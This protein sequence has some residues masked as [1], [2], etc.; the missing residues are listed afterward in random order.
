M[1][2][3]PARSPYRSLLRERQKEQTGDLILAA[4][5]TIL[6]SSDISAVTIA[7]VAR[8]AEVTER[9]VYRHFATRE[10]LLRAFWKETLQRLSGDLLD[11]PESVEGMQELTRRLFTMF[12]AEEGVMRAISASP[13]GR[14]FRRGPNEA[15]LAKIKGFLDPLLQGLPERERQDIAAAV[16]ALCSV[17]VWQHMRDYVG[18]DGR[19]AG[20]ATA[21]AIGLIVEAGRRR[22]AGLRRKGAA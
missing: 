11:N 18:F 3:E 14:A 16:F 20:E 5:A 17:P 2:K 13:E 8:V 19:R 9:T 10:D 7:E 22:A 21:S 6:R 15:R 1:K 12:D 4:V